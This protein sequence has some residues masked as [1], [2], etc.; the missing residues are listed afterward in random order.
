MVNANVCWESVGEK[1]NQD[2]NCSLENAACGC[3]CEIEHVFFFVFF[4]AV[5]SAAA[6]AEMEEQFVMFYT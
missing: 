3:Y 1:A 6:A 2:V 5:A 4:F